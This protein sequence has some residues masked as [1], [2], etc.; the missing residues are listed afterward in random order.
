MK[1][2]LCHADYVATSFVLAHSCPNISYLPPSPQNIAPIDLPIFQCQQCGFVQLD[3]KYQENVDY[4]DYFM[5]AS[6]SKQLQTCMRS[7]AGLL[8]GFLNE[9]DKIL[10]VGCGD[11]TFLGILKSYQFL[12]TGLEP[13]KPFFDVA[14]TKHDVI[15]NRY[16]TDNVAG[17]PFHAIVAREVIEHVPQIHDFIANCRSNLRD[18]GILFL[19][20]PR[21]ETIINYDRVQNFFADH[22]NYFKEQ[23]L[24][25][26]LTMHGFEIIDCHEDMGGEFTVIIGYKKNHGYCMD[27]LYHYWQL[28]LEQAKQLLS[29]YQ[30]VVLYGAGGKGVALLSALELQPNPN[31]RLVDDDIMKHDRFTP[32]TNFLI[33]PSSM[34]TDYN[35]D[36]I[37]ILA[38]A[39]IDEIKAKWVDYQDRIMTFWE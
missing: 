31:L 32:V 16:L 3:E 22:L 14:I 27:R 17:G 23:D 8:A 34:I 35:P 5:S 1:C 33:E 21:Y 12:L 39:Y 4:T 24:Q 28:H 30:K 9:N 26:L 11:G 29:Q 10:E 7:Q 19:Q 38:E 18:D 2:R 20:V 36:A 15:Y 37:I 25:L 6:A 13:S